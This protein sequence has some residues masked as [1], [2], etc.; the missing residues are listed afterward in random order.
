[1]PEP[2]HDDN[3]QNKV[4]KK[5]GSLHRYNSLLQIVPVGL[6]W[7]V[8]AGG[9]LEVILALTCI[10]VPN[11]SERL[12][13]FTPNALSILVILAIVVQIHIYRE[14]WKVMKGSTD[15]AERALVAGQR[16]YVS[17]SVIEIGHAVDGTGRVTYY[18]FTPRW[19]NDG[20]TP[21]RNFLNHVS[22]RV[23]EGR[24]PKDWD[25]EDMWDDGIPPDERKAVAAGI[26]P[27]RFIKGQSVSIPLEDV[28]KVVSEAK[29]ALIW[30]WAEY[31]DVFPNT[32]KHVSRIAVR[33]TAGGNPYDPGQVVFTTTF[34]G[35][36]NCSD[37]ECARQGYPAGWKGPS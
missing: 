16:A 14:Q 29:Q 18:I 15:I 24:I 36:Y 33:I 11:M 30:G 10:F 7:M 13:F 28:V 35:K 9:L 37:G 22:R 20:N 12:K 31:D 3:E 1:M 19:D 8:L 27:K 25:V 23:Y 26:G 17:C 2:A 6:R 34:L 4:A 21:T 5:D 32:P